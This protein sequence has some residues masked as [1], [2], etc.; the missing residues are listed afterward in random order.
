MNRETAKQDYAKLK[1]AYHQYLTD[2]PKASLNGLGDAAVMDLMV[3]AFMIGMETCEEI[4]RQIIEDM[5]KE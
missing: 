5:F 4:S 3:I 1:E 2:N